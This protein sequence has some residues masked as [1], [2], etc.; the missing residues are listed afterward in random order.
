MT[1]VGDRMAEILQPGDVDPPAVDDDP[2][3]PAE[4]GERIRERLRA[5]DLE[6]AAELAEK[7]MASIGVGE[8]H[9]SY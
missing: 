1:T 3:L 2:E 5:R 6:G 4:V 7:V 9:P 8:G